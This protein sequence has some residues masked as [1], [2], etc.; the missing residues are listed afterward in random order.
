MTVKFEETIQKATQVLYDGRL[1]EAIDLLRPIYD[2][3]PS[4]VGYDD[5][6]RIGKDY[7]MMRDYMLQG[8]ADPQRDQLYD[9]LLHDLYRVVANL[10]LSPGGART[11]RCT[12]Q[13]F[14]LITI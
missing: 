12:P 7:A 9:R 10:M 6:D 3:H 2:G 11:S 4:L 8:Y 13:P 14:A 1:K 5:L